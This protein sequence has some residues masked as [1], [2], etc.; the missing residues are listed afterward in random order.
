MDINLFR[1]FLANNQK[2]IVESK[3]SIDINTYL[4]TAGDGL[5]SEHKT[6]VRITKLELIHSGESR[7]ATLNVYFDT[8][9]WDVKKDGLI[10]T[11][12]LFI[13]QLRDFL[14]K[15]GFDGVRTV[16]YTDQGAS[17][18][19]TGSASSTLSPVPYSLLTLF[20]NSGDPSGRLHTART[21]F[22]NCDAVHASML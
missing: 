6:K 20:R 8:K 2:L 12:K 21:Q 18:S 19:N 4:S 5:W 9:T 17:R 1:K 7:F 16:D 22:S 10:Y 3:S 11:D 13:K 15:K 14:M